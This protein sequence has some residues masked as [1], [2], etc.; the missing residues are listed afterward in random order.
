[1]QIKYAGLC[2]KHTE[3]G[4]EGVK[5]LRNVSLGDDTKVERVVEEVVVKGELTAELKVSTCE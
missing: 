4:V 2:S 3:V 5:L 1:M